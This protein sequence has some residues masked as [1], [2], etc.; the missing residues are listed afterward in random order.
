MS[1]SCHQYLHIALVKK[2]FLRKQIRKKKKLNFVVPNL[3]HIDGVGLKISEYMWPGKW[4]VFFHHSPIH[5]DVVLLDVSIGSLWR[6]PWHSQ[7]CLVHYK[8]LRSSQAFRGWA[9]KSFT[10]F[11]ILHLGNPLMLLNHRVHLIKIF[12]E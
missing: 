3:Y 1:S 2:I 10:G 8:Q 4:Y 12:I 9:N 7:W 6:H 11:K 5:I